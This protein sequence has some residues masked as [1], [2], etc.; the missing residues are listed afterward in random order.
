MKK[1]LILFTSVLC[2]TGIACPTCIGVIGQN[3]PKF[4]SNDA[5]TAAPVQEDQ[6]DQT[7]LS[8]QN[9]GEQK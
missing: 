7:Q 9:Q 8:T 4:F 2:G 6:T 5:Y 1:V 3:S